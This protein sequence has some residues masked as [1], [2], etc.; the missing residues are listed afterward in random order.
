MNTTIA[1]IIY[2]HSIP[3]LINCDDF[4]CAFHMATL[5]GH[6]YIDQFVNDYSV[7]ISRK[8]EA[9]EMRM[10]LKEYMEDKNEVNL[11]RVKDGDIKQIDG[12]TY[13]Y[14]SDGDVDGGEWI[15]L[16]N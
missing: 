6:E 1:N 14:A 2:K 11:S 13:V 4:V 9:Y 16:R 5:L 10:F 3:T 12:K 15:C 7:Q 8:W